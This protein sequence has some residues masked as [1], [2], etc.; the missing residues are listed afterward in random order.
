MGPKVAVPETESVTAPTPVISEETDRILHNDVPVPRGRKQPEYCTDFAD[1]ACRLKAADFT[2]QDVAYALGVSLQ[3]V[4]G[5]KRKHPGFKR[6]CEDGR[7]EQK[8]RIIAKAMKQA[9]GYEF[10][11][12]NVKTIYDAKGNV[13][14]REESEFQK[15]NPGNER[16][17]VFLLTNIDR[18]LGDKD[19]LSIKNIEVEETQNV[20]IVYGAKEARAQIEK[21]SGEL[22]ETNE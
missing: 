3:T 6:A 19:W 14:K 15:H 16:L 1:I 5:W 17:L 11:D 8:K 12:R 21:L 2:D 20:K 18:Q 22:L 9:L 10:T 4:Q 7:R 13:I